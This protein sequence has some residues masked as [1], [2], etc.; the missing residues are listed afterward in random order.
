MKGLVVRQLAWTTFSC[1]FLFFVPV[2]EMQKITVILSAL[3]ALFPNITYLADLRYRIDPAL[4]RSVC[5]SLACS[6][7][8][9]IESANRLAGGGQQDESIAL[10]N[11]QEALW[12]NAASPDRW[13][14]VGEAFQHLGRIEEAKYSFGRAVELGPQSPP[15]FWRTAQ[16]YKR[17]QEPRL[18]QEYMGKM[19]ALLPKYKELVFSIY[20]SDRRDVVDTLEYGIP[21]Q[22]PLSRDYFRY[23]LAH[24]KAFTDVKKA[25][26]WLQSH[27]L[28]DDR[29]AGDYVDWL[30]NKGEYSL[31][32]ETWKRSVGRYDSA[33]LNPNF[34]FNGGF[35]SPPLQSGL[36]WRLSETPGVLVTRDSTIA[37][38][39]SSSLQIEFDGK[40]NIDFNSVT[41]DIV[42]PPG[43]YHF[44]A[45]VRTSEVTT[46]QG[47]GFRLVDSSRHM[48][49]Q[50][51]RLTGTH[52]WTPMDLDFT[53]S[54]PVQLLRIEVVRQPSW[55]FD[56]KISGKVWIDG[57]SLVRS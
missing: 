22:S 20:L 16:F 39:G 34:V 11:L 23:I 30:S 43:R 13:C 52:D 15:V 14:D 47:V 9:L 12:R 25:W 21:R 51:T 1:Y 18:S 3:L 38:S 5:R 44:K 46:D 26:E 8:L 27:S 37:F 41:H 31:G 17:I 55:K 48:N 29:L 42:A 57:V 32:A 53:L 7:E 33:Y 28:A 19:L 24:D 50:T 40:Q 2:H 56:N 54:G 36:D 45:W 49:L 10:A 35:E 4:E 6:D